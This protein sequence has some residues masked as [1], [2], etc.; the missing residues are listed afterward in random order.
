MECFLENLPEVFLQP[1]QTIGG[2]ASSVACAVILKLVFPDVYYLSY[3]NLVIISLLTSFSAIIGDLIESVIKRS[4][5]CKDSGTLIPGR[6]GVLDSIDSLL[7]AAPVF[8]VAVQFL[9]T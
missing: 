4:L 8:Y 6:G 5:D 7:V 9:F 3:T 1:V 2:V